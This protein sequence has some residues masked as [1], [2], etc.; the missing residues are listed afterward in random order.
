[1]SDMIAFLE[2]DRFGEVTFKRYYFSDH[3][4]CLIRCVD[5]A[6]TSKKNQGNADCSMTCRSISAFSNLAKNTKL[7]ID[8]R[9]LLQS[10]DSDVIDIGIDLQDYYISGMS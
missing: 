9:H 7:Q 4:K 3:H 5:F 10:P 1:M 6:F 8:L 2:V